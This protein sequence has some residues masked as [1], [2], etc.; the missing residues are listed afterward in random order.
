MFE[1]GVMRVSLTL[2]IRT[3][4][5]LALGVLIVAI[6]LGRKAPREALGYRDAAPLYHGVNG[7]FFA[8]EESQPRFLDRETG[9]LIKVPFRSED[10]L[11][12]AACSPWRDERGQHHM[13]SRWVNRS[14]QGGEY[15]PLVFGLA[16]FTLPEG[17]MIDRVELDVLPI[18]APCWFPGR[19]PQVLFAAGNGS[20]YRYS[21]GPP[22]GDPRQDGWDEPPARR[23]TWRCPTPGVDQVL[24]ADLHWPT[25]P[26]LGGRLIASLSYQVSLDGK[27][28]F[29]GPELWWLQLSR[30]GLAIEAAGRLTVAETEEGTIDR[31]ERFPTAMSIPGGGIALAYLTRTRNQGDWD[32]RVSPLEFDP[33]SGSPRAERGRG[34]VVAARCLAT[35]PAFSMDGRWL[36]GLIVPE[37][38]MARVAA[39]RFPVATHLTLEG[40]GE[41]ADRGRG[42]EPGRVVTLRGVDLSL[43]GA[44]GLVE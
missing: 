10:V 1:D 16:R 30:D 34:R 25:T 43:F 8:A 32:L 21:F 38:G 5:W 44:P 13:V 29:R 3:T 4:A 22:V 39:R 24:V 2:L 11:D 7:R 31:E 37:M 18:G 40:T 12:H 28:V 14:G 42:F 15:L 6:G 41:A 35:A 20:I 36:Y 19:T 17:R 27:R 26:D 33:Q 23:L 9:E